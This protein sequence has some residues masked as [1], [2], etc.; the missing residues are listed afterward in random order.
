MSV[1]PES[2]ERDDNRWLSCPATSNIMQAV[3]ERNRLTKLYPESSIEIK[4]MPNTGDGA[5]KYYFIMLR[6]TEADECVFIMSEIT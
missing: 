6:L 3:S 2:Y 1:W 4:R 5:T